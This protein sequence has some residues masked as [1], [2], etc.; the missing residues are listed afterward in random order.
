[1][2]VVAGASVA[3]CFVLAGCGGDTPKRI[4]VESV[5]RHTRAA[6]TARIAGTI[7]TTDPKSVA[8]LTGEADLKAGRYHIRYDPISDTSPRELI[9]IGNDG[10]VKGGL[11]GND[12]CAV[13]AV[14]PGFDPSGVLRSLATTNGTLQRL[15]EDSVRDVTATH[16]RF[17][18]SD[19]SPMDLWVDADDRLRRFAPNE[20]PDTVIVEFYDFGAD[21]TPVTA[22]AS[23][24]CPA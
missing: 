3:A 16:Y 8:H 6:D 18:P 23:Q 14:S 24:S 9:A 17:V 21:L 5:V 2:R 4:T 15:G 11:F 1:M 20:D 12:W 10:F 13:G 7:K 19:G 22:P